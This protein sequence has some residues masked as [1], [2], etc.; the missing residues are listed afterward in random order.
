MNDATDA[1][2]TLTSLILGRTA[3]DAAD[4]IL[5][6]YQLVA[7]D[8]NLMVMHRETFE[9]SVDLAVRRGFEAGIREVH[10]YCEALLTKREGKTDAR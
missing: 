7:R 2:A 5:R 3:P 6:Q 10:G 4:Q 8:E 1:R 9:M